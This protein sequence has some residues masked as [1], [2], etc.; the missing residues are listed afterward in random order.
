[1][2][3]R[4]VLDNNKKQ[5]YYAKYNQRLLGLGEEVT[6]METAHKCEKC[7]FVPEI[8]REQL[9]LLSEKSKDKNISVSEL[10]D[11]T[12]AMNGLVRALLDI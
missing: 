3:F 4:K 1:M 11:L 8:L 12:H 10:V 6:I 9:E 7:T 5:C 2:K